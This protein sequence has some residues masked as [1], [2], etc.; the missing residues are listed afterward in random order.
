MECI[1]HGNKR[2]NIENI[3]SGIVIASYGDDGSYTYSEHSITYREVASLC[4]TPETY[5]LYELYSDNK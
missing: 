5:I 3:V 1:T 4:C 2:Y